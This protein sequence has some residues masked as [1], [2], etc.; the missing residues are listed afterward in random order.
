MT[1]TF[2][3]TIGLILLLATGQF[4]MAQIQIHW[5]VNQDSVTNCNLLKIGKFVNKKTDC[6]VT[7]GYI[8][9]F[10]EGEVIE[11]MEG[12]KYF[13]KSKI[14]FTSTC[15]YT[16]TILETN[17][18]EYKSSIGTNVY[19][20]ILETATIDNLVKIRAKEKEEDEW[21]TFVF[22]KTINE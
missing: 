12:G 11:T 17:K 4:A 1:R 7:E 21:Q 3:K 15:S 13:V 10:R 18:Q 9:E 20:E 16:L 5:L 22:E 2:K 8:I 6:M 14:I 19:G